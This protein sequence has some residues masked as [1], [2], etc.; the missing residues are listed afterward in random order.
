MTRLLLLGA[1][2]VLLPIALEAA[3]PSAQTSRGVSAAA[4][5]GG[6]PI[7]G[8]CMLSQTAVLSNTKVALAADARLKQLEQQA[9]TELQTEQTAI[10]NDARMLE[11]QRDAADFE[12]RQTA[13]QARAKALA[14]KSQ[15]RQRELLVTKQKVLARI[16]TEVQPI[17]QLAFRAHDCSLLI[18]RNTVLLGDMSN[19]ITAEVTRGLDAKITTITFERERLAQ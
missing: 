14:Q 17:V 18:D 13:L 7:P 11:G 8:L 1:A 9:A 4:T 3:T 16:S 12:T 15:L 5:V 19:D 2:V 10:S 6:A